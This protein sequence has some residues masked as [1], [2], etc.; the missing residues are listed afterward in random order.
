MGLRS[1]SL[2]GDSG[3]EY[4][5]LIGAPQQASTLASKLGVGTSGVV[6][7]LSA[8]STAQKL[9]DL[10]LV[11][12]VRELVES[13]RGGELASVYVEKGSFLPSPTLEF[14]Q[15]AIGQELVEVVRRLDVALPAAAHSCGFWGYWGYRVERSDFGALLAYAN[16]RLPASD[17]LTP[18]QLLEKA[19]FAKAAKALLPVHNG[20]DVTAHLSLALVHHALEHELASL[21][22][23][24]EFADLRAD[25]FW[26]NVGE[27]G[28]TS[29]LNL[30]LRMTTKCSSREGSCS[31][32]QNR[33]ER[34]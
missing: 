14:M 13:G 8:F 5:A 11:P 6:A 20:S 18:T 21:T 31:P 33:N 16:K 34:L 17:Q 2:R 3:F 4:A 1:V 27:W 9:G 10:S 32:S 26:Q 25:D 7:K 12:L 23:E 29:V 24:D 30:P 15:Y 22:V 19:S 28:R